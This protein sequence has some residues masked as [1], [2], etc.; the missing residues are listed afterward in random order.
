MRA[1]PPAPPSP[2][3][4]PASSPPPD[5]PSA[6]RPPRPRSA[7]LGECPSGK[8]CLW[9]NSNYAGARSDLQIT[10]GSLANELFNDGPAGRNGWLVQVEDNA[11]SVANRT[12]GYVELYGRRNCQLGDGFGDLQAGEE[13]NLADLGLKNKVSSVRIWVR[14]QNRDAC[15]NVNSGGY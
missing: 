4:S 6:P 9:F 8:L 15:A 3:P 14:S 13:D 2:Q 7:A 1:C 10:D 11:A 12:G 5:S